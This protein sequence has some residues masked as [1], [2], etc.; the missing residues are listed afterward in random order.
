MLDDLPIRKCSLAG[1][2]WFSG[3]SSFLGETRIS[4]WGLL[5]EGS[6]GLPLSGTCD[7]TFLQKLNVHRS[8]LKS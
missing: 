7:L 4:T 3:I 6:G 1:I 8:L 5:M 2:E